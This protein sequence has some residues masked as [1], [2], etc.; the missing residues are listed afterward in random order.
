MHDPE[1]LLRIRTNP[2]HDP[3]LVTDDLGPA[4]QIIIE[5]DFQ[6]L[7]VGGSLEDPEALR[8]EQLLQATRIR[9]RSLCVGHVWDEL[10]AREAEWRN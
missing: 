9:I 3:V 10:D 8:A 1:R 6:H 2:S 4:L 5:L 7:D